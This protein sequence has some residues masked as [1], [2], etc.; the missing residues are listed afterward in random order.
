MGRRVEPLGVLGIVPEALGGSATP[1]RHSTQHCSGP[2]RPAVRY[3]LP[4]YS[5]GYYFMKK[6]E[7]NLSRGE[8]SRWKERIIWGSGDRERRG[9]KH[10]TVRERIAPHSPRTRPAAPCRPRER[11]AGITL[12]SP[13]ESGP[14]Q[15]PTPA[16]CASLE[17]RGELAR[18]LHCRGPR[19]L[20]ALLVVR[21]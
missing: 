20:G 16:V 2:P 1:A 18:H 5:A 6:S 4:Q 10:V 11:R 3:F 13:L 15:R 14:M 9:G 12:E 21:R 17:A 19:A 8:E 7:G